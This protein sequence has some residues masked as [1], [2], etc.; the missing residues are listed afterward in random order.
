MSNWMNPD[1][2]RCFAVQMKRYVLVPTNELAPCGHGLC[3]RH[4]LLLATRN[5]SQSC[6]TNDSISGAFESKD[7]HQRFCCKCSVCRSWPIVRSAVRG[8]HRRCK[9]QRFPDF[10]RWEVDVFLGAV[11]HITSVPFFDLFGDER[12]VEN[13]SHNII[14]FPAM[15]GESFQKCTA[16]KTRTTQDDYVKGWFRG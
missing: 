4:P 10:E 3:K 6:I 7:A 11:Y 14:V 5:S 8:P 13:I 16:S 1:R 12:V 9:F 2:K 15:V